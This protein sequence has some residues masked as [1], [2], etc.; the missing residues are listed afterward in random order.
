VGPAALFHNVDP[1]T[2]DRG[3]LFGRAR[4]RRRGKTT[5]STLRK[6]PELFSV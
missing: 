1:D 6:G 5:A 3:P 4:H 2:I